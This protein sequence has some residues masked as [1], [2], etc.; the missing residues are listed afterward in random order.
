MRVRESPLDLV[1][2]SPNNAR[3]VRLHSAYRVLEDAGHA[4]AAERLATEPETLS[5]Q[6]EL[7][8][9]LL[10]EYVPDKLR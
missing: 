9:D 8:G 7:A 6:Q 2:G 1:D 4:D 5:E 10:R 3:Q